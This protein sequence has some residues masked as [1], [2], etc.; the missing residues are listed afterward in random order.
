TQ[1]G[2]QS[3]RNF[4]PVPRMRQCRPVAPDEPLRSRQSW[5]NGAQV[6]RIRRSCDFSLIRPLRSRFA[7]LVTTLSS[8]SPA[9]SN[10]SEPALSPHEL[11]ADTMHGQEV[12]RIVWFR[13]ELLP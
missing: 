13:L 11:V 4:G 6:V 7:V 5:S 1:A 9:A 12:M 8:W 10:C 2:A 3:D